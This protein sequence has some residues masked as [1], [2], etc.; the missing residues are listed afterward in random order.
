MPDRCQVDG[1]A[2][3]GLQDWSLSRAGHVVTC[4]KNRT[5]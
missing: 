1:P 2:E 4:M 3:K 5:K